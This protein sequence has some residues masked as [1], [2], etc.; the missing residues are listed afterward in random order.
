MVANDIL[1]TVTT[2]RNYAHLAVVIA[3]QYAPVYPSKVVKSSR[4]KTSVKTIAILTK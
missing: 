2:P 4:T 3:L 1:V